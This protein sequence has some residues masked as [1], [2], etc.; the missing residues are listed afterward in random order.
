MQAPSGG[1]RRVRAVHGFRVV[2]ID[3]NQVRGPDAREMRLVGVHQKLRA[4]LVDGNREVVCHALVKAGAVRPSE[5]RRRA[6]LES[7]DVVGIQI[8]RC[9]AIEANRGSCAVS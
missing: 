3:Q 1:I 9:A 8:I 4:V 6:L 5:K 2:G 7:L